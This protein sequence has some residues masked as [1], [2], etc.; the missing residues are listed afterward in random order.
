M[1]MNMGGGLGYAYLELYPVP[2]WVSHSIGNAR[3]LEE[4]ALVFDVR[5]LVVWSG[6]TGFLDA[7]CRAGR[8]LKNQLCPPCPPTTTIQIL[9]LLLEAS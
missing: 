3:S 4:T 8:W 9:R 5:S 6:G 7:V 2:L 1:D